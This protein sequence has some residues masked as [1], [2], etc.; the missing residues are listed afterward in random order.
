MFI[1]APTGGPRPSRT[2]DGAEVRYPRLQ[3]RVRGDV[4]DYLGGQAF[5]NRVFETLESAIIG[6]YIDVKCLESQ[7]IWIGYD[8]QNHPEWS[9]NV[10]LWVE[11]SW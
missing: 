6:T 9:I 5:T 7:P 11:R 10:E 1:F 4:A 8:S 2:F 3:V